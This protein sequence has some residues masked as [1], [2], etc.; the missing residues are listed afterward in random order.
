MLQK[1]CSLQPQ[2]FVS[3]GSLLK[4]ILSDSTLD[5][6]HLDSHLA[7]ANLY[8]YNIPRAVVPQWRI[9]PGI[10]HI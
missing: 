9:G 10:G 7:N 5:P 1:V 8:Y 2:H 4:Y 3:P 6:G